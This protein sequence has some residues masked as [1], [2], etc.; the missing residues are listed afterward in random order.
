MSHRLREDF[1][2]VVK[3]I[4]AHS[5]APE[6][7]PVAPRRERLP[8]RVSAPARTALALKPE[9]DRQDESWEEF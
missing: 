1:E 2:E 9:P 3:S 4:S 5:D 8:R 7:A 6:L